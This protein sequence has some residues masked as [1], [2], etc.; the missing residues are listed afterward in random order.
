MD[1]ERAKAFMSTMVDT[2]N[3]GSI[4]LMISIG[5]R[6][7]LFDAM[8]GS[9]PVTSVELAAAA[10]LDERYVRE[11][12]AAMA[13]GGIVDY[14][15]DAGTFEL[16]V[17]HQMLVTRAGGPLNLATTTQTIALLGSVEDD[18]VDAFKTGAGVP[19]SRYPKFQGWMAEESAKRF[20]AAL[21][22]EMI[23]LIPGAVDALTSGATL[24]DVGCGSGHAIML[25]ATRFPNSTFVGIDFSDDGLEAARINADAAGLRNAS[26]IGIDAAS[27]DMVDA[28]DFVTTFD[29]IHDQAQPAAVLANIYKA[30]VPGGYYLC[31]EPRA[32]SLLRDNMAEPM[33]P[34]QYTM[35]TMHCMSVS[36]AHGGEGL[37]TCWGATMTEEYLAAAGFNHL[38]TSTI[39]A[40]RAN[41]YFLSQKGA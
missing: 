4:A 30:L 27:M 10:D 11:W 6:T 31:A 7:G 37:G 40:D 24:A 22:D 39:K 14:V 25:L 12:L 38:S 18:I 29:A 36:I 17:E 41:S 5:H 8:A 1:K 26:F 21:I 15:P 34:Y 35:S 23:P 28:Y 13:T 2:I 33:S 20:D 3:A 19:Y 32:H 9:G 16:P